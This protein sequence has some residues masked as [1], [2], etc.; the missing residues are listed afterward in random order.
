MMIE[1]RGALMETS[2]VPSVVSERE[3]EDFPKCFKLGPQRPEFGGSRGI[4]TTDV[5]VW[6]SSVH[7]DLGFD[8]SGE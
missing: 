6:V 4:E 8:F 7:L 1:W 3:K 2:K 5:V